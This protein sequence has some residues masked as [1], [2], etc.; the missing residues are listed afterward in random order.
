M[1]PQIQTIDQ[2]ADELNRISQL[3]DNLDNYFHDNL[4]SKLD[5]ERDE[6]NLLEI[7]TAEAESFIKKTEIN[8]I[9]ENPESN[10]SQELEE[11]N[12]ENIQ[13]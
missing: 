3:D 6:P 12:E 11:D 1:P 2:A 10:I 5:D 4:N 8:Y 7:N 9:I 13:K